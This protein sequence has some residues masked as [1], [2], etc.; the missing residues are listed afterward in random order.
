MIS[1]AADGK[2]A[3][4]RSLIR[5]QL[6]VPDAFDVHEARLAEDLQVVRH[7]RLADVHRVDDLAGRHRPRLGGQQVEDQ[8]PRRVTER[9][10]P[11]GPRRRVLAGHGRSGG[12]SKNLSIDD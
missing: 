10:E 12:S 9:L 5:H 4:Q 7:G 8:D 6:W 11:A 1:S 2:Q 3:R